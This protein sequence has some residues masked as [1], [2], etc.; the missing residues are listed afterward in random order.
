MA[1]LTSFLREYPIWASWNKIIDCGY[2]T[3]EAPDFSEVRIYGIK[4]LHLRSIVQLVIR[5][6]QNLDNGSAYIA[7]YVV[8]MRRTESKGGF[9]LINGHQAGCTLKVSKY[10]KSSYSPGRLKIK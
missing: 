4:Q 8:Y 6:S 3:D 5:S 2:P 7:P 1:Y 9:H 10:P